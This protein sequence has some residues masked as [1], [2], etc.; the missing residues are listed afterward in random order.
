MWSK[1]DSELEDIARKCELKGHTTLPGC[2]DAPA[3]FSLQSIGYLLS[4][5]KI[6][7]N[8]TLHFDVIVRQV[9]ALSLERIICYD[10]NC[11]LHVEIFVEEHFFFSKKVTR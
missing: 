3:V 2:K 4:D 7:I 9:M 10:F 5:K 11:F 8:A 6:S 1:M